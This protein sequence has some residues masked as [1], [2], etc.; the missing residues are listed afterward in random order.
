MKR[1]TLPARLP[2]TPGRCSYCGFA[3][4]E[5][6]QASIV[7]IGLKWKLVCRNDSACRERRW[8]EEPQ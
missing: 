2:Q 4:Y 3:L 8:K 5:Q 6:R 1:P 7:K